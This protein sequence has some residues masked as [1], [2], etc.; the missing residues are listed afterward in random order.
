MYSKDVSTGDKKLA[1]TDE[2]EYGDVLIE[3]GDLGQLALKVANV[4]F[5]VVAL[6]HLDG[7]EMV[8][9]PLSLSERRI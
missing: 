9:F 7:E 2:R 5:E 8:I 4:R 3:I 6:L 1:A